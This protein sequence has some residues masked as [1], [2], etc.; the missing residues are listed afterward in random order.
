VYLL[1]FKET[2]YVCGGHCVCYNSEQSIGSP[3]K[4]EN[5]KKC[6][7]ICCTGALQNWGWGFLNNPNL[8]VNKESCVGG[9]ER[10]RQA[11]FAA[12]IPK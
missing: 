5:A 12:G 8:N 10:A 3:Q 2:M 7:D 4:A 1:S 6:Y 9:Q 11:D